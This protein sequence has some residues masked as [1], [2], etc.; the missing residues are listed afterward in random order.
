MTRRFRWL[1]L[2]IVI[3]AAAIRV[4]LLNHFS[5][6]FDEILQAYRLNGSSDF[7][8]HSLRFDGFHPPLDY[9]IDRAVAPLR[10]ADAVRKIPSV[11]WGVGTVTA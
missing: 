5:Y 8:W 6:G 10:P 4:F 7:F 1:L 2:V 11:L 9:V 3:S